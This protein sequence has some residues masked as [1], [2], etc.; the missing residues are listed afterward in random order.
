MMM[1]LHNDESGPVMTERKDRLTVVGG[2]GEA[3]DLAE[4][5]SGYAVPAVVK[6]VAI[7][8]MINDKGGE[9]VTLPDLSESLGITRS[10]CFGIL[11]TLM[12]CG[13]IAYEPSARLYTLSAGMVV[14]SSSALVST[15][16][17]GT[18]RSFLATLA[19]TAGFPCNLCEVLD[20][21]TYLVVGVANEVMPTVYGAPVGYRF[22][23]TAA[24][25]LKATLAW[26]PLDAQAL[27]LEGWTPVRYSSSTIIDRAEMMADLKITR[28]RGFAISHGEF[29]EG[30][31]TLS[32]PIFNRDGNV[33]LVLS[34][35]GREER[36]PP[37][38]AEVGRQLIRTVSQIHL[39]IDG[40]PPVD[41][42]RD[43]DPA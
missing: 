33:F 35:F 11:R 22:P 28:T 36:M 15:M 1:S 20:D 32:L 42:P 21:G 9:G 2:V 13:W 18:I 3:R 40:R 43:V 41:F 25:C 14:D 37:H 12:N 8:R 10:H 39:A 4:A 29:V 27:A 24:H 17:L 7:V 16:H 19:N 38:E 31:E 34:A 23:K 30:F 5:E 6:T 26:L